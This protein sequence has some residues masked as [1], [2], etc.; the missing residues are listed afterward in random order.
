MKIGL[1]FFWVLFQQFLYVQAY[2]FGILCLIVLILC[3]SFPWLFGFLCPF[4]SV[5]GINLGQAVVWWGHFLAVFICWYRIVAVSDKIVQDLN[6]LSQ[7][8]FS[9]LIFTYHVV[10]QAI[11]PINWIVREKRRY[12]WVF[13]DVK[14]LFKTLNCDRKILCDFVVLGNFFLDWSQE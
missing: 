2:S 7:N 10:K 6:C 11:F 4:V 14:G 9:F 8:L 5:T 1:A 3:E 13:E 12:H